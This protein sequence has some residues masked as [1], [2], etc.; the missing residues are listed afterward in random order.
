MSSAAGLAEAVLAGD[1]RAAARLITL[2]ETGDPSIEPVLQAL[3]RA[4]GTSR[5]VG[6]TGPPGAGKSTLVDRLVSMLRADG[7]RVAILAVDPSSPLTGGAVLGDRVRMSRHAGDAGV[8]IR[9]MAARGALGGLSHA[10]GDALTILDA[11]C[12]DMIIVETVGI[13]QS[14]VDIL[15]LAD[16]VLLLQTAQG[17]DAVQAVKAGVLEIADIIVVNKAEAPGSDRMLRNLTEMAAHRMPTAAGWDTPVLAAEAGDGVGIAPILEAIEAFFA[18]RDAHPADARR[19][20]AARLRARILA[21]AEAAL[22]R[23]VGVL[24]E[25]RLVEALEAALDRRSDPHAVAALLVPDAP[26]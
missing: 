25:K 21:L 16:V 17:G 15:G 20:H 9:S 3:Y 18:C 12:F 19:R 22:R 4:G 14:E 11:L 5:V 1:R 10:A 8:F 7:L 24:T 13:G 23:R 2:A 26:G 6:V